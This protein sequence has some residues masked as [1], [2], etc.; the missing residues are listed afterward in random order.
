MYE[1]SF[2]FSAPS[3]AIGKEIP[4]PKNKALLAFTIFLLI[5]VNLAY[6]GCVIYPVESTC[7]NSQLSWALDKDHVGRMNDWYQQWAKSGASSTYRIENPK[8]YIKGFNWVSNWYE[9]YF[10][11]KFKELIIGLIS[12]IIILLV[13]FRGTQKNHSNKKKRASL[14]ILFIITLIL[15][16]EWFYYHPALR[17]GG[18]Y[19]VCIILFIPVCYYLSQKKLF[20]IKKKKVIISLVFISFLIF[21]VRN[22]ER[23]HEEH[24][25]VKENNF[26]LFFSPKQNFKKFELEHGT[27]L[28][29]PTDLS[30]CWAI[31][32]PCVYSAKN[33]IV[34][35]KWGYI[36]LRKIKNE[37]YN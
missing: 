36:I 17:Y 18:Y 1:I 14:L 10:L 2:N 37:K 9:R 24:Q 30:G 22:I 7:L 8:E 11:Y 27:N 25:I 4:L 32:T 21:C 20:F 3:I 5:S 6:T 35:K 12:A 16:F 31:K 28:Y 23:I 15:F 33:T 13:L 34:D 26:P 19:L 29:V